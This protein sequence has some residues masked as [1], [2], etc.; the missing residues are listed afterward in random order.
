M[1]ENKQ[2]THWL[3]TSCWGGGG[4]ETGGRSVEEVVTFINGFDVTR[5]EQAATAYSDARTAV[6]TARDALRTQAGELAKVWE[7]PASVE[8]QQA[9]RTLYATMGELAEK[10][11]KMADPVSALATVVRKHQEFINDGWKGVMP[12]WQNQ[13]QGGIGGSWNDSIADLYSTYTGV[14]GG[15]S[16]TGDFGSADELA[17]LHLKTFSEDLAHIHS[18][19]PDTV[20]KV[21][22]DIRLPQQPQEGPDPI[23]YS[24]FDGS[25]TGGGVTP[26][27]YGNPDLSGMPPG[28]RDTTGPPFGTQG[29]PTDSLPPTTPGNTGTNPSGGPATGNPTVP[30]PNN[31]NGQNP[32]VPDP[33]NPNGQNP[34]GQNPGSGANTS[35]QDYRPT[36]APTT[37]PTGTTTTTNPYG[38]SGSP[39]GV[40]TS[41]G[42]GGVYGGG[43]GMVSTAGAQGPG[44]RYGNGTG[45]PFMPMGGMGGA[46]AQ[47]SGDRE[48]TTWLHEDDD[49]WDGDTGS[50]VNSKIG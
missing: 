1:G 10:L 46:G 42:P 5:I 3:K 25:N 14:Y 17:G 26:P 47:E 9:L 32:N 43:S 27:A 35:L 48:S 2:E 49:V 15:D 4:V 6:N 34:N 19:I 45:T 50:A 12:T 39:Y 11:K 44:G 7:G 23:D 13:S 41:G 31:P 38:G 24:Q 29:P 8:A 21:L 18:M 28:G 16:A 33:N 22:R 20:E 37:A 40:G 30:D 36:T